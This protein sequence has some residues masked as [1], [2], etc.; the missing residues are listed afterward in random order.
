MRYARE[1]RGQNFFAID[2]NVRALLQRLAPTAAARW[3]S[4]LVDFGAWVGK[5]VD[6]AAE[7]TDRFAP[8]VLESYTRGGEQINHIR[9]NPMWERVAREVYVKGAIGLNYQPDPAPFVTTFAMGYLLSQGDVALHCPV[10]MTGAVAYV[11]DRFAPPGVKSEFLA[12]LTR[13]DGEALSGGTWATELHGGSDVGATTTVARQA[14]DH[15]RLTGLK[16]FTSNAN[17]GLAVATARPEGAPAGSRGLG[18]YLVPT[19]LRDGRP[20]PMRIRRLKDKLGTKGIPTGEIDLTDT[21]SV[22]VAPPPVGFKLMMEALGFSRIHNAVGSAGVARRAFLEAASYLS[23]REAFGS[24]VLHYPMVQNE[25]V[26]ML[27]RLESSCALAFAAAAA[28]D[29]ARVTDL[30]AEDG[31][32]AWLRMVTALA[33]YQNAEDANVLARMAIEMIGGNAY[34]YD[35]VTPRLLRDAQVLTVWEGPAN[36]QALEVL[37]MIGN[38]APGFA[39]FEER[40]RRALDGAPQ[41]LGPVAAPIASAAT[42][43]RDAIEHVRRSPA[44]AA[45]HARKVMVLLA[46]TLGA[47]LLLEEAAADW[48]DGDARKAL[49]LRAY[50]EERLVPL[51][52]DRRI[53]AGHDWT[54]AHFEALLGY[55]AIPIRPGILG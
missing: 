43:C 12:Q 51:P 44:E 9:H 42:Q 52:A 41:G 19:H 35:Y 33:K 10:T 13:R 7:Y 34:T 31:R 3:H 46:D 50:N 24:A 49:V 28:F 48:R 17:G 40:V 23:H 18:L 45:R 29:D 39:A 6:E 11:L 47:A 54:E 2:T 4:T 38:R 36:I 22:E 21:W 32:R 16:W 8:P 20:N 25:F 53:A 26:K 15:V 27:T 14:G 5:D 37:R 55:V 30:D 1:T